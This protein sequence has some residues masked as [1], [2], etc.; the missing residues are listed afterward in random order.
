MALSTAI[1]IIQTAIETYFT[2]GKLKLKWIDSDLKMTN[3]KLMKHDFLS[4]IDQKFLE[5]Y[6]PKSKKLKAN[7]NNKN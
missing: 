3:L 4:L 6:K 5:H 1:V 2:S 7:N